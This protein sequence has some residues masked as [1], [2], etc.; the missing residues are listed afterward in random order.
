MKLSFRFFYIAYVVVLISVGL[1]G[2]FLIKSTN[3]TLWNMQIEQANIDAKYAADSFLALADISYT[4][5]SEHWIDNT[6]DQIKNNLSNT[7]MDVELYTADTVKDEFLNLK[8]SE[9]ISQFIK[10]NNLIIF[11]TLCRLNV[12]ENAYYLDRKSVV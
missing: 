11:E 7:V 2:I 5:M 10:E 8:D 1:S 9:G 6:I 3:D 4:E 12:G